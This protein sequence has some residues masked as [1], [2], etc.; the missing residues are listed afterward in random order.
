M[1]EATEEQLSAEIAKLQEQ[2]TDAK[3]EAS[4]RQ[5][6]VKMLVDDERRLKASGDSNL[7]VLLA[8]N[9]SAQELARAN[10]REAN[11]AIKT[12]AGREKS[13]EILRRERAFQEENDDRE[14]E[15]IADYS[16]EWYTEIGTFKTLM[17]ANQA[18]A[19]LRFIIEDP[20]EE[21]PVEIILSSAE[22]ESLRVFLNGRHS[23]KGE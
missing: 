14:A 12:L 13:L 17:L 15:V 23:G 4:A 11:T 7:D 3:R 18:D 2:Q 16:P 21:Y 6:I 10:A 19:E 20:E 8:A 9:S 1:A 5:K 22:E